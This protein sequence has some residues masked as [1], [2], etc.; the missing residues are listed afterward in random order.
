MPRNFSFFLD[1]D[2]AELV[3]RY[4]KY[5][6]GADSGYFDVEEM[7]RIVEYYLAFGRTKDSLLA[8]ELGKRLHPS[9]SALD[10]KRAKIYLTTGDTSK[11]LRILSHLIED[12]DPEII[13]LK[14]EAFVKLERTQEAFELARELIENETDDIDTLCVELAVVF[15]SAREFDLTLEILKIGEEYNPKNLDLLFDIAFCQEQKTLFEDALLTYKRI[16][17]IDSY[18]NEAWFNLGQVHF[19]LKNYEEAIEAYDY[20]LAINDSDNLALFQKAHA[21]YQ[22]GQYHRAINIYVEYAETVQE[23]WQV[24]LYI[25]ESFEKIENFAKALYYYK[26]SYAEMKDNYE[27]LIGIAVSLLELE[28][29]EESLE[30]IYEALKMN[31]EMADAWIY[32]A[33]AKIGLGEYQKALEAY[34]QAVSID[35]NQPDSLLAMAN[36]YMDNAD[37]NTALK[38]YELAY[39]YDPTLEFIELFIAVA[40]YYIGDFVKTATFLELAIHRNLDA[41]KLFLEF[42]PDAKEKFKMIIGQAQ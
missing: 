19:L 9:S 37:F 25:G 5:L 39:S 35:P 17:D 10:L 26:M 4:E 27:A 1:D 40:T 6:T 36:I 28:Q 20:A 14:I 3:S 32:L 18:Q 34:H 2:S 12:S 29:F 31:N 7:E 33:E 42:C 13:Y 8:V 38:Y 30:Y 23:K 15:M 21:Y 24:W 11:A 16:L 22:L 41:A